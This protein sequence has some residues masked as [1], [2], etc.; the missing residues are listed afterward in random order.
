MS[1]NAWKMVVL[2]SLAVVLATAAMGFGAKLKIGD[3]APDWA[4]IIGTD[5]KEH[6]LADYGKAKLIVL[7]FTCNHCP[8]AV[9]YE[10]RLVALQKDYEGKGVQVIAINVN[11]LP[12]DKLEKMKE[13][14]EKKGFTFPYLYDSSQKSGRDY[15]ATCTPHVFVLCKERKIAYMGAID[16]NNNARDAKVHFLRDALDA[17]LAGKSPPKAITTQR[18]CGIKWDK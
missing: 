16:D 3:K 13:R 6:A 11:N 1:R 2:M 8:V 10:D 12:A 17:L 4:G 14:A 15:G 5:D 7:V 9:V 18:G